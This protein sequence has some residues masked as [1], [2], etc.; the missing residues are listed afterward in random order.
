MILAQPGTSPDHA[1]LAMAAFWLGAQ[2]ASGQT[3]TPAEDGTEIRPVEVECDGIGVSREAAI[4]RAL[5]NA[6]AHAAATAQAALDMRRSAVHRGI[7]APAPAL[8][9]ISPESWRE[10]DAGAVFWRSA[11]H[12]LDYRVLSVEAAP[13][14]GLLARV[15]AV[16]DIY[17]RDAE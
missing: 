11:G 12:V 8:S 10:A 3:V 13:G 17:R 4:D 15:H 16:I 2:P 14:G 7:E 1:W 5:A 6:L 9:G